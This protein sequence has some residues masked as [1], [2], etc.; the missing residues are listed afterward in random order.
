VHPDLLGFLQRPLGMPAYGASL[1]HDLDGALA[2]ETPVASAIA[3]AA[4]RRGGSADGCE[5]AAWYAVSSSDPAPLATALLEVKAARTDVGGVPRDLQVALV[6]IVRAIAALGR[7]VTAARKVS[8]SAQEALASVPTWMIGVRHFELSKD[9]LAQ[10]DAV[11]VDGI[12]RA[13]VKA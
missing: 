3:V 11:D 4:L 10:M 6:P 1:A 2:A 12:A 7:D 13:A 8:A 5:D 9:I